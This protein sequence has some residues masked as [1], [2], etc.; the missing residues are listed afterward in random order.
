ML[1]ITQSR[2]IDD[3]PHAATIVQVLRERGVR[4]GLDDVGVGWSSIERMQALDVDVIKIDRSFVI[5]DGSTPRSL[6]A[7]IIAYAHRRGVRV[8]AEGI[9]LP[10]QVDRLLDLGCVR[11]QGLLFFAPMPPDAITAL[12]YEGDH[13]DLPSRH[14]VCRR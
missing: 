6:V 14:P 9:E 1:E 4:I 12:L 13:E 5:D 3:V 7:A 10:R 11:G 8:V 2:P